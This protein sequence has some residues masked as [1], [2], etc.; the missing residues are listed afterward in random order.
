MREKQ[1]HTAP[2]YPAIE[3]LDTAI[4]LPGYHAIAEVISGMCVIYVSVHTRVSS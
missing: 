1:T 3:E 2:L 4:S